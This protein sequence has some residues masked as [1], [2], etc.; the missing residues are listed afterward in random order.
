[1]F[2]GVGFVSI[3]PALLVFFPVDELGIDGLGFMWRKG[4]QVLK[5]ELMVMSLAVARW[6]CNS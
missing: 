2:A 6:L 1:M 4:E 5:Y 3:Y